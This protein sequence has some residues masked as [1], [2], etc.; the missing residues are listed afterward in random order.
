[1]VVYYH[2]AFSCGGGGLWE[3]VNGEKCKSPFDKNPDVENVFI[4]FNLTTE[5]L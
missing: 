3:I 5:I 1:L 4:Y 2:L